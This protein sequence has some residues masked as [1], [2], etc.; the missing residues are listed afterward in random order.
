[1]KF[2]LFTLLVS[3][4]LLI[5]CSCG[6][7][8]G[9]QTQT[10]IS[11]SVLDEHPVTQI[12]LSGPVSKANA[13]VSGMA[14]CGDRLIL[15]PQFPD[16]FQEEG[17]GRVFSINRDLI[18]AY[19][20]SDAPTPVEPDQV[21]F[22]TDGLPKTISGFEGFEAIV[23]DGDSVFVTIES[24]QSN[25]MMGYLVKGSVNSDCS[26][27]ILDADSRTELMP[28]AALRNISDETI[29]IYNQNIYTIY[30]AN[31]TTINPNP[32]AH[33]FDLNLAP[34]GDVSLPNIEYRLTDAT[35]VAGDGSF[36]A[37]NYF[38][39]GDTKLLPTDDQIA[40]EF[41]IG[42]TNQE[43]EQVERIIRMQI[44]ED[45]IHLADVT[46]IYLTLTSDEANN[47]EGIVRMGEGFLLVTDEYPTTTLGY[48]RGVKE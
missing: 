4:V 12:E 39:P 19:V 35:T 14:W 26:Q 17:M 40:E 3:F 31:G 16:Q 24:S 32:V 7:Q 27:I 2:K 18:S 45:G 43:Y 36:W 15:L 42:M 23:F 30:E 20:D 29:L 46:P 41:G 33:K 48:V 1:M 44:S 11:L 28:Q 21:I 8:A 6:L 13:E 25:G 5:T 47:W 34:E 38:F 22:D 37:I 9:N 10:P